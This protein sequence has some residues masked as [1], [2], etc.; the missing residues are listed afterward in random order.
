MNAT[1]STA[2]TLHTVFLSH[3]IKD[4]HVAHS[5]KQLLTQHTANVDY[6]VSEDI[7]K[8]A[9]WRKTITA[10][11]HH[12]RFL[13]LVFTDPDE[14]WS[15]C[16]YETGFFDALTQTADNTQ[17]RR[18]HCL[19][20]PDTS[21]PPPIAHLQTVPATFE[22][23]SKWLTSFFDQT[24]QPKTPFRDN[25]QIPQLANEIS[26]FFTTRS[27]PLY[28]AQ[29]VN[30]EVDCHLLA[31]P[32]DLPDNTTIH[33]ADGIM[34]E[35]F[36][37]HTGTL[38]WASIKRRFATFPNS[39]EANSSALKELSRALY[40]I[41][42]NNRVLPLQ[43]T[44]FV[45][46]GPK[47]YRP[48]ISRAK[49][50]ST[51]RISCNVL[52]VEEVGGPLQNVDKRLGALLTAV[53]MALRIRWEIVRPFVLLSNVRILARM[54]AW[55]L[56]VDLQTCLNNIFIEAEFRGNFS[57]SDVW[58][59]FECSA[60]KEKI[61]A[62]IEEWGQ[63]YAEIW[64][65]IGFMDVKETFGEVSVQ[66]FSAQDINLLDAG[67][68]KLEEM[69]RDFLDR[70][71]VRLKVLV[72]GELGAQIQSGIKGVCEELASLNET[73]RSLA[74]HNGSGS[75]SKSKTGRPPPGGVAFKSRRHGIVEK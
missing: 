22:E 10:Q 31:S 49:E 12:S 50:L 1:S 42:K 71:V 28:A 54:N 65:S 25:I 13:V 68:R 39:S 66:P 18:I 6:F 47:R 63:L 23:V 7:E 16:L 15:W 55:K 24:Q 37:T 9:N 17:T 33:G 46:E 53:R 11:L 30:I 73:V 44:I 32:E 57:P 4:K 70:A 21:A 3:R 5:I 8:G 43:S 14:D 52:L 29:S 72:H 26:G 19:H 74:R 38:D 58:S 36:G 27:K 64:Q 69:N 51:G 48:V 60:D 59:A 56:R 67:M 2:P 61:E 62:M 75:A 35:L 41:S 34:S 20:H 40:S 45:E